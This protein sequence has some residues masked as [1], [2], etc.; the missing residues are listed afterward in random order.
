MLLF[1]QCEEG[2]QVDERSIPRHMLGETLSPSV[3]L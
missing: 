2:E 1:Y 3:R